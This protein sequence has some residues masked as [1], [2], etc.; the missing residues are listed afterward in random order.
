MWY[1]RTLAAAWVVCWT[2]LWAGTG[3]AADV[4]VGSALA[5]RGEVFRADAARQYPLAAK[6]P[7]HLGDTIVTGAG[8]AEISLNDGT[9]LSVGE[10]TRLRLSTYQSASNDLT[11]RLGLLGG[12]LRLVV[13][14]VT[15]GGHF[16]VESETAIA[17]VRGTDWMMAATADQT[18][19]ALVSGVVAVS[20]RNRAE[21]PVMLDTPGQGTDVKRDEPPHPPHPWPAQRF[22]TML[23][24]CNFE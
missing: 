23:D 16:E 12:V 7:V 21:A 17:A 18:G 10:N 11:T 5:V 2:T 4:I 8:K 20:G 14:R 9:L 15:A 13:A 6:E 19:V 22:S 24:R 3:L 1:R